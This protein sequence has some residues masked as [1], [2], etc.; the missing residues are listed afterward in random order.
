MRGVC[1][2]FILPRFATPLRAFLRAGPAS[3]QNH[4]CALPPPPWSVAYLRRNTYFFFYASANLLLSEHL[5]MN[6]FPLPWGR[7]GGWFPQLKVVTWSFIRSPKNEVL[8]TGCWLSFPRLFCPCHI[9][10]CIPADVNIP[11]G[12]PSR[13]TGPPASTRDTPEYTKL[14]FF[15]TVVLTGGGGG[16]Q[17]AHGGREV[18]VWNLNFW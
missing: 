18:L 1:V 16:K 10:R 3:S 6:R 5:A 4:V 9:R 8:Q 17:W 12:Y 11:S 13:P 14:F 2:C 7:G 15:Q